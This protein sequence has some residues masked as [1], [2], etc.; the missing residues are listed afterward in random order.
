MGGDTVGK[1]SGDPEGDTD[2]VDTPVD[3]TDTP[4]DDTIDTAR[5][6]AKTPNARRPLAGA[7]SRTGSS[8]SSPGRFP[9]SPPSSTR[10]LLHRWGNGS[11]A[12][13]K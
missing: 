11:W 3:D 5:N 10:G 4:V 6:S 7:A 12:L 1:D 8:S 9:P 2:A 13:V